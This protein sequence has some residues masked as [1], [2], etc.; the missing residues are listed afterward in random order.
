MTQPRIHSPG[1]KAHDRCAIDEGQQRKQTELCRAG[2]ALSD[3][4]NWLAAESFMVCV[5]PPR[6]PQS[7]LDANVNSGQKP[8]NIAALRV[9]ASFRVRN[10]AVLSAF[11]PPVP[12]FGQGLNGTTGL[13]THRIRCKDMNNRQVSHSSSSS[14]IWHADC[15]NNCR[16][17]VHREA[18]YP[19]KRSAS[20]GD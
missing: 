10:F 17:L 7:N 2:C 18:F 1:V 19:Q 16:H 12:R 9:A 8:I 4:P 6:L 14:I 11:V 13:L 3:A 5:L 15:D 20:C